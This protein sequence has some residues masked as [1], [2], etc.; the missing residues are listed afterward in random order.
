MTLFS[1]SMHVNKLS[2][3]WFR[4]TDA[5]NQLVSDE[6]VKAVTS[7]ETNATMARSELANYM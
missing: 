3:R 6:V 4:Y 5:A 7:D 1:V 2:I